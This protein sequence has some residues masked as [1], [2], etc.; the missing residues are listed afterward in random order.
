M[1]II[2]NK[3]YK[4]KDTASSSKVSAADGFMVTAQKLKPRYWLHGALTWPKAAVI[5]LGALRIQRQQPPNAAGV[6]EGPTLTWFHLTPAE[7]PWCRNNQGLERNTEFICD[8]IELQAII[9]F[10]L[11]LRWVTSFNAKKVNKMRCPHNEVSAC[12]CNN[13]VRL[14]VPACTGFGWD[15]VSFLHSSWRKP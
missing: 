5:V 11:F 1:E 2:P 7:S 12:V 14:L 3:G 13:D 9:Q 10:E 6:G 15:K 4:T 8:N